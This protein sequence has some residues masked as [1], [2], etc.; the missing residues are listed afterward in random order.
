MFD[1]RRTYA[2]VR[3]LRRTLK[4]TAK[5]FRIVNENSPKLI[6]I[7]KSDHS[8]TGSLFRCG[9]IKARRARLRSN[10]SISER[11]LFSQSLAIQNQNPFFNS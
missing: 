2:F 4:L 7:D 6:Q 11:L 5:Y 9:K 8:L 10:V 3:T 1:I